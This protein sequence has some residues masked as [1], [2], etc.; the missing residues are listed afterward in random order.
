MDP[1]EHGLRGCVFWR[2]RIVGRDVGPGLGMHRRLRAEPLLFIHAERLLT[3]GRTFRLASPRGLESGS[4]LARSI[5]W[6]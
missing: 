6:L 5:R 2:V 3:F 1:V 4:R